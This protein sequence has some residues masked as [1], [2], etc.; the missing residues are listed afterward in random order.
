M[1]DENLSFRYIV[2]RC[3]MQPS[4]HNGVLPILDTITWKF[5]KSKDNIY[6]NYINIFVMCQVSKD[7]EE[8]QP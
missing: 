4:S 8:S 7:H 1:D 6:V 2:F 3:T 5:I